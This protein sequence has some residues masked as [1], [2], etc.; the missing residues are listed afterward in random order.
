MLELQ[1]DTGAT[2]RRSWGCKKRILGLQEKDTGAAGERHWDTALQ[3]TQNPS[4]NKPLR[5]FRAQRS[6]C[7][8][9][10]MLQAAPRC[11]V[12]RQ[13]TGMFQHH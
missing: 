2:R 4:H 9:R 10:W 7:G 6:Q 8:K 5:A 13:H 3:P 1:E 11:G 12:D